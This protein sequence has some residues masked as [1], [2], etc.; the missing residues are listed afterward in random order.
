MPRHRW[1]P[2]GRRAMQHV[3]PC[4]TP[5]QALSQ[6]TA[7]RVERVDNIETAKRRIIDE[8]GL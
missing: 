7:Y 2:F 8:E 5:A 1:L 4:Q 6:S 3:V